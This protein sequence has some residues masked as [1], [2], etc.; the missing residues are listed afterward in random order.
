MLNGGTP[1]S[2]GSRTFY[3]YA[4]S[5]R[6]GLYLNSSYESALSTAL[7]NVP[8]GTSLDVGCDGGR[9][10][11]CLAER[12][13][14]PI[15]VDVREEAVEL[16]RSRM[17]A[18]RCILAKPDDR[19]LPVAD[20]SVDLLLVNEV[21]P[22]TNAPWFAQEA[23]RVL[24]TGGVLVSTFFNPASIRGAFYR[25]CMPASPSRQRDRTY[26]GY[27][28]QVVR[29]EL[30]DLGFELLMT[31]GLGW[32]P[33]TRLSDSPLIPGV[34]WLERV[35]GLRRVARFS[36]L[37]VVVAKKIGN[38]QRRQPRAQHQPAQINSGA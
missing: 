2:N 22:V 20:G 8:V 9:L 24:A 26:G 37:V 34:T 32:G 5:T 6:W 27:S 18:A 13:W 38:G 16:C 4:A 1:A 28:F 21:P 17:P 14:S 29:R 30:E 31:E 10:S 35:A 19:S 7:E 15:C 11:L 23:S 3:E 12:G 36:P 33:F 25:A